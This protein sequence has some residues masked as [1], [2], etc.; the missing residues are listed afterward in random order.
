L[1]LLRELVDILL[2]CR[3]V[4]RVARANRRRLHLR[5]APAR[6]S[7][8]RPMKCLKHVDSPVRRRSAD[9]SLSRQVRDGKAAIGHARATGNRGR[10]IAS[11]KRA[12]QR[13]LT[14]FN[15]RS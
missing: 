6:D 1:H 8:S 9:A 13:A 2:E 14:G 4:G 10:A 15:A 3:D 5:A 11:C 7:C 12:S